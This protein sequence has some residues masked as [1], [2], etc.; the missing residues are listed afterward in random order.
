MFFEGISP[1]KDRCCGCRGCEQM[2]PHHAITCMEDENGFILPILDPALCVECGLC[3]K[4]CPIVNEDKGKHDI[5]GQCF[6]SINNNSKTLSESS[7]GGVFS[8]IAEYT[9]ENNGVVYGASFNESMQLTH[10]RVD[11]MKE[12]GKLRGSKYLQSDTSGIFKEIK[13]L[14]K[15]GKLVYFTGTGCQVAALK[16]YLI[17]EYENLI[18]SDILCHGVPNHKVFDEVI[19]ELEV[20]YKGKV[21]DYKFRDKR[22]NGWSCSSS[23]EIKKGSDFKY[24]GYDNIMQT[25]FNAFISGVMNREVCYKCPFACSYRCGDIT[26]GD[27]WGVEKYLT[28]PNRRAGVSAILVNSDK[29]CQLINKFEKAGAITLIPA[30]IEDVAVINETLHKPTAKPEFRDAF[31]EDF[32][33]SPKRALKSYSNNLLKSYLLYTA[34]RL[35]K[36]SRILRKLF[37][38]VRK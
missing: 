11:S 29:G 17:K 8:V 25:Y 6:A 22:I 19:K 20:K 2:C 5:I 34:K 33:N 13:Q 23:C 32:R 28:L 9:L 30:N 15:E 21:V 10:I 38:L 18:T 26:L 24:I 14:L 1:K 37:Y 27:F 35:L 16:C 3:E 36:S 31:F 7:S 4:V 12:L